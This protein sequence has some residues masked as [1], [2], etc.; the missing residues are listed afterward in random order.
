MTRPVLNDPFRLI[1]VGI[2]C[3]SLMVGIFVSVFYLTQWKRTAGSVKSFE[4][5]KRGRTNI[6]LGVDYTRA[7]GVKTSVPFPEETLPTVVRAG[8]RVTVIYDP[9]GKSA[10]VCTFRSVWRTP[11]FAAVFGMALTGF[12]LFFRPHQR[13]ISATKHAAAG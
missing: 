12:G 9:Q 1:L 13:V 7:N 3:A 5:V 4:V 10:M 2:G 6:V 8:D 11:T